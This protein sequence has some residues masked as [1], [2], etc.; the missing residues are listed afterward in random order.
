MMSLPELRYCQRIDAV[1]FRMRA[2]EL[3]ERDLTTEIES[4]HQTIVSSCD[5]K[6][7]TL[8]V[9]HL[10]FWR[11]L[12]DIVGGAPLRR[13]HEPV[14]AV[15]RSLCLG[16]PLRKVDEDVPSDDFA[17]GRLSMFPIWEQECRGI[18]SNRAPRAISRAWTSR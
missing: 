3:H 13:S 12:L 16:V 7:H 1:I 4:S 10:G 9:Q 11:R 14:P 18:D 6:S 5:L 2:V 15:D 17:S 8:T